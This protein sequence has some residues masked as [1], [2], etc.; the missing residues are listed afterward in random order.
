M[1]FSSRYHLRPPLS[2]YPCLLGAEEYLGTSLPTENFLSSTIQKNHMIYQNF[3]KF[4]FYSLL[5]IPLSHRLFAKITPKDA[6]SRKFYGGCQIDL[7][8]ITPIFSIKFLFLRYEIY[9]ITPSRFP[10]GGPYIVRGLYKH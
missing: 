7:R 2:L 8:A 10:L 3:E 6:C 5:Q 1:G 9:L 4:K